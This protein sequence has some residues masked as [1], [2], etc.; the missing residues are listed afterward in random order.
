MALLT[1]VKP[2]RKDINFAWL[3]DNSSISSISIADVARE[4]LKRNPAL[5]RVNERYPA[6]KK[7]TVAKAADDGDEEGEVAMGQPV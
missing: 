1:A 3:A 6:P 7:R 2:N 4:E 5:K